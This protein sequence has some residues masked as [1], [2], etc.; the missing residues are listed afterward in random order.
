MSKYYDINQSLFRWPL[1]IWLV[2]L[3]FV[4]WLINWS[5]VSCY[6]DQSKQYLK[7]IS[8][9]RDFN[10]KIH[11]FIYSF[12]RIIL[13]LS[14]CYI[15]LLASKN[16]SKTSWKNNKF[17]RWTNVIDLFLIPMKE[18]KALVTCLG[19]D[20]F[21]S[22]NSR[23]LYSV[24]LYT[25]LICNMLSRSQWPNDI[26]MCPCSVHLDQTVFIAQPYVWIW[27]MRTLNDFIIFNAFFK[28]SR[29]GRAHQKKRK[30]KPKTLT[31]LI[32]L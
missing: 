22:V 26:S 8:V 29:F 13:I 2:C 31:L 17:D 25:L 11:L 3:S 16:H 28:L 23:C 1:V 27:Q 24:M 32:G 15:S 10:H 6:I 12:Y 19:Q 30:V 20:Q 9:I 4:C 18:R 14:N 21:S 7:L 5:L